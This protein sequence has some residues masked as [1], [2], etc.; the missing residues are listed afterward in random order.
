MKKSVQIPF[1]IK[2]GVAITLLAVG[3]TTASVM[4]FYHQGKSLLIEQMGGRLKDIGR[5]ASFL[6]G[7]PEREAI[8]RLTKE[9]NE[10]AIETKLVTDDIKLGEYRRS[11][12]DEEAAKLMASKD[13]QLLVAMLR[14]IKSASAEKAP[15]FSDGAIAKSLLRYVSIVT[16]VD[17]SKDR[18]ILRFLA[19][20]D[21]DDKSFPCPIGNL[22]YSNSEAV[23]NAFG[24]EVLADDDFRYEDKQYLLSAGIPIVVENGKVL[25]VLELYYDAAG[26]ANKVRQL[27]HWCLMI[28]GVSFVLSLLVAV[29]LSSILNRPIRKL[30]EGAEKV[31]KKD[32]QTKIIIDTRDE[33]GLLAG[34][35]NTMVEEVG[36]YA[37]GLEETNKAYFRFVPKVFLDNLGQSSIVEVAL[38][39]QV[40]RQMTIL[41]ADIR[42][43]TSISESMSPRDNF[44]FINQYLS[45]VSPIIRAHGG[46]VDKYIGDGIMAL[47]PDKPDDAVRAATEMQH[48]LIAFN[49]EGADLGRPH[50]SIG[51]GIHTG[52][53]ML[54]TVG[55]PER[56]NSTVI[57]DAVNLCSRIEGLTKDYGAK[58]IVS[59]KVFNYG[60]V[61]T[62]YNSRYLGAVK[63]KGKRTKVNIY[64]L[65]LTQIKDAEA[66]KLATKADFEEAAKALDKRKYERANRYFKKVLAVDAKDIAAQF[67]L[68]KSERLLT[69]Q[70][71]P[72]LEKKS[73]SLYEVKADKS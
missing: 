73:A 12:P 49:K 17:D 53:L 66:L 47:F 24:G 15:L 36:R 40:Q 8:L 32:F 60:Q 6:I 65:I 69:E 59:E 26:E 28:I 50:V 31:S 43:F 3:A 41:F 63:V 56:M 1:S 71:K 34:A 45:T 68:A 38:G 33:L 20:A 57:S 67:L 25:A 22:I 27:R 7:A 72:K 58:I 62:S 54:G 4:L 55:E 5:T 9:V 42:S 11:L 51:I 70:S 23:R 37:R 21:Y 30:R 29:L 39:D 13:F 10:R 18:A 16:T 46:F 35:F 44:D 52:N 61:H 48:A 19:D 14:K 64:E 2:L